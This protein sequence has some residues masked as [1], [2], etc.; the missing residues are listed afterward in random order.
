MVL[1]GGIKL[2]LTLAV[3]LS[4]VLTAA[5][6]TIITNVLVSL[7]F[8]LSLKE[9]AESTGTM[10]SQA[11]ETSRRHLRGEV[12]VLVKSDQFRDDFTFK[13]WDHVTTTLDKLRTDGHAGGAVV[14]YL[15][16]QVAQTGGDSVPAA[17]LL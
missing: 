14:L 15:K 2:K 5:A 13:S 7:T 12:D 10:L 9:R 1:R 3:V 4:V 11:L 6:L 8:E 16:S 17:A